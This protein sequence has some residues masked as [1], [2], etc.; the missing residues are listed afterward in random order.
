MFFP[1]KIRCNVKF[2]GWFVAAWYDKV[3]RTVLGSKVN[4][5]KENNFMLHYPFRQWLCVG[6]VRVVFSTC[7]EKWKMLSVANRFV[8]HKSTI[9]GMANL[10][11]GLRIVGKS[12][13]HWIAVRY[14]GCA[15]VKTICRSSNRITSH[16]IVYTLFFHQNWHDRNLC[17]PSLQCKESVLQCL[18][19]IQSQYSLMFILNSLDGRKTVKFISVE[20]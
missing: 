5:Q 13:E 15:S 17:V 1:I 19:S 4:W 14:C 3:M 18:K 10:G 20:R 12:V 16:R 7:V 9:L 8:I 11:Y 2:S 6:N